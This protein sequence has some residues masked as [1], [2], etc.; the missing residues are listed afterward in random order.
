MAPTFSIGQTLDIH[1]SDSVDCGAPSSDQ[2]ENVDIQRRL[3]IYADSIN[4]NKNRKCSLMFL[5]ASDRYQTHACSSFKR[6]T[7]VAKITD[8]WITGFSREIARKLR[9]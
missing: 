5:P 4:V 2:R 3:A 9:F 6:S 7:N 8:S 1:G